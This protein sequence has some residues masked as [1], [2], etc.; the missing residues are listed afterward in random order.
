[1]PCASAFSVGVNLIPARVGKSGGDKESARQPSAR[2]EEDAAA[3]AGARA[4]PARARNATHRTTASA[5]LISVRTA[6]A[7]EEGGRGGA[8]RS[9][10]ARNRNPFVESSEPL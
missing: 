4:L 10:A 8:E 5:H 1:M 6:I 3:A 7:R 2:R 9:R